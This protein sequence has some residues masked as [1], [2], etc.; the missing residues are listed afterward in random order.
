MT[1]PKLKRQRSAP[2]PMKSRMTKAEA[3]FAIAYIPVHIFLL[4]QLLIWLDL[5]MIKKNSK[6]AELSSEPS[7]Q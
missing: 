1:G 5:W 4:P 7:V 3:A 6:K 2:P